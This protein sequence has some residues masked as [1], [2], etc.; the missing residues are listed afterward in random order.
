VKH[1]PAV[2]T[3][4]IKAMAVQLNAD[5]N[6]MIQGINANIALADFSPKDYNPPRYLRSSFLLLRCLLYKM[7]QIIFWFF[8]RY[9]R[10]YS[11]FFF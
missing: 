10:W 6:L 3:L 5:L 7:F 2:E 9:Q 4:K 11:F 1:I 8:F